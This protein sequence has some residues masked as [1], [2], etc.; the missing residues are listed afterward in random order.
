LIKLGSYSDAEPLCRAV[1]SSDQTVR[2]NAALLLGKL[3]DRKNVKFLYW[4]LQNKD[5]QDKVRF[6]AAEAIAM[7]GDERIYPKLW[8]ML[9][10]T[11]AD[12]RVMGIKAM[13]ALATA[14]AKN[15][16]ITMLKDDVPE[17]RLAAAEQLG[18][19]G[20]P[21]GESE[22][23]DLYRMNVIAKMPPEDAEYVKVSTALAIGRIGTPAVIRYLP[24][25]LE[26]PSKRVRI[27]AAKAVFQ[28]GGA[29]TP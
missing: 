17:V 21:V 29:N 23:L 8:A 6:Q 12:D 20:N 3:G 22:V 9:I 18:V 15:A 1:S 13:G 11:Y 10:S 24:Q 2:A 16:V 19:L 5:S 27:A 4:A 26:D 25:L 28:T 7:L 14:D